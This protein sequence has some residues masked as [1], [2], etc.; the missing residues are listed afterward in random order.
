MSNNLSSEEG[1]SSK[2]KDNRAPDPNQPASTHKTKSGRSKRHRTNSS[3]CGRRSFWQSTNTTSDRQTQPTAIR[4]GRPSACYRFDRRASR[5]PERA[6]TDSNAI[7]PDQPSAV[8]HEGTSRSTEAAQHRRER[9]RSNSREQQPDNNTK[10]QVSMELPPQPGAGPESTGNNDTNLEQH[11]QLH[12]DRPRI[13]V[14][15]LSDYNAGVLHGSWLDADQELDDLEQAVTDM[16][17][18]SPSP[19]AEE[20]AI[21][22]FEGFGHY[23][24]GEYDSLD[25]VSRVARGIVEHGPAFGAWAEDCNHDEEALARFEDAY[26]G[27]WSSIEKYAEEL[28]DD[29]GYLRAIDEAV[30]EM[31]Q[32]YVRVDV[33][34]F[35]RDL[36]LSGDVT[37]VEHGVGVWLFEGRM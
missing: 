5:T 30:P 27:E 32:P 33:E 4:R 28:L 14:A 24:V 7:A 25:W 21:H 35:A 8:A 20:F 12:E 34:A 18:R 13:Y 3:N 36:E 17:T 31:L 10:G 1:S 22:D 15:S 37:V 19:S 29:L 2:E 9:P 16:L 11:E 26:L 6:V 23:R